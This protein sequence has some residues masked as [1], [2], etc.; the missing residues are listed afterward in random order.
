MLCTAEAGALIQYQR[1][2]STSMS[3]TLNGERWRGTS[4]APVS[5]HDSDYVNPGQSRTQGRLEALCA[6]AAIPAPRKGSRC[7]RICACLAGRLRLE[8]VQDP[9]AMWSSASPRA[10]SAPA[11]FRLP[12]RP[13]GHGLREERGTLHNFDTDPSAWWWMA[14]GS[15]PT[16]DSRRRQRS[17]R[18]CRARRH[19]KRYG[20]HGPLEFVFTVTKRAASPALPSFPADCS[21]QVLPQSR[22]RRGV[23][24]ASAAPRRQLGGRA[25]SSVA[26]P[27]GEACRIKISGLAG[28]TRASTFIA[29]ATPSHP[30][31]RAAGRDG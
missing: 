2:V 13:P 24:L 20:R 22:Q 25:R 23:T 27:S 17:G 1:R 10:L 12:F 18:G 30:R 21:S 28:A 29:P 15:K 3:H 4:A 14:T 8:S 26:R 7:P 5:Y 31:P 6:L 9:P 11:P 19:G 16:H